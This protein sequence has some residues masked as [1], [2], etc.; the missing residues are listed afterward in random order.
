MKYNIYSKTKQKIVDTVSIWNLSKLLTAYLDPDLIIEKDQKVQVLSGPTDQ[1]KLPMHQ[2]PL[3]ITNIHKAHKFSKGKNVKIG[4]FDSGI[5]YTHKEFHPENDF[6]Q[7]EQDVNQADWWNEDQRKFIRDKI[8]ADK[9][10]IIK[11]GKNYVRE[12]NPIE[13]FD[14]MRHATACASLI[15]AQG[16]EMLGVA[17]EAELFVYKVVDAKGRGSIST[18]AKALEDAFY[19]GID[20]AT[21]SLA[22]WSNSK[23]LSRVVQKCNQSGMLVI[24]ATGNN[25]SERKLYPSGTDGVIAI[26]GCDKNRNRWSSYQTLGSNWG[27]HIKFVCPASEQPVALRLNS[28]YVVNQ[29]TSLA[30]PHFAGICALVLSTLKGGKK[31]EEI[32]GDLNRDGRVDV[33][34]LVRM[35]ITYGDVQYGSDLNKDGKI[36]IEDLTVLGRNYGLVQERQKYR[37]IVISILTSST[38]SNWNKYVGYGIPDA[39][40]ACYVANRYKK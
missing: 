27:K 11:Y 29:G 36:D 28:R 24:A 4:I 30:A 23:V 8:S 40:T 12:R 21:F 35:G 25:N 6:K 31:T 17:P 33:E 26:G 37:E 16:K 15:S 9:H 22:F 38:N 19:D 1:S 34:D 2:W 32:M 3:S 14:E 39:E 10:S 7:V 13:F 5:D 20:I 18:L